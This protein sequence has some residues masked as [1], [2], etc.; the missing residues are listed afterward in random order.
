MSVYSGFGTRQQESFYNKLL[1][2]TL[3]L[4]ALKLVSVLKVTDETLLT[5]TDEEREAHGKWLAHIK[6]CFKA[7]YKMERTKYLE[8]K[9]A[10]SLYPLIKFLKGKYGFYGTTTS[11]SFYSLSQHEGGGP[12]AGL[13]NQ[14]HLNMTAASNL[15]KDYPLLD[16]LSMNSLVSADTRKI[17]LTQR[18]LGTLSMKEQDKEDDDEDGEVPLFPP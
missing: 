5:T 10:L 12:G 1:E 16:N 15:T 17:A 18:G 7:I 3:Q 13:G 9:F 6:K 4:L 8:P 11:T 14:A 2:R